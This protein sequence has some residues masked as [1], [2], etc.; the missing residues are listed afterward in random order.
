[1]AITNSQYDAI[2]RQYDQIRQQHA[3]ELDKR[4]AEIQAKIP[5]YKELE[6]QVVSLSMEYA[7]NSIGRSN[8]ANSEAKSSYHEKLLDI[9][10]KKNRLLESNGYP[11]DYLEMEYDCINCKDTGFVDGEKC[12]CFMKKQVE[13]VYNFSM[14]KELLTTNNF[15]HLSRD[16]Y[17]GEG[18][19]L[20]DNAVTT[21]KNFVNNFFSDYHNLFFYGTVGTGKSFLSGCVAKELLDKGCSIIYI[22]AINLFQTISNH[23]YAQSK[24]TYMWINDSLMN[25][26]LLI[27]DDL[28]TE[29]T[30]DFIRTHLFEII[31]ERNLMKKSTIISTNLN[32]EE[33][34]TRYSDR[35][36]SRICENYELLHLTGIKDIRIQKKLECMR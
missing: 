4:K 36:F 32:M 28:G 17:E 23:I 30:N 14:I 12:T 16:Y 7:M 13:T 27:I 26:D 3:H 31:N 2:I 5:E 15:D 35:V 9:K 33:I 22:S 10:L 24:D 21:C 29:T 19:R 1:M 25:C 34:R 20:F 6:N 8:D 18:L 11:K